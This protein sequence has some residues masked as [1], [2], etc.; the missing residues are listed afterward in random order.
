[1]EI[2]ILITRLNCKVSYMESKAVY[3]RRSN[4]DWVGDIGV[5]VIALSLFTASLSRSEP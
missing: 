3:R 1:M 5:A 2:D 4:C